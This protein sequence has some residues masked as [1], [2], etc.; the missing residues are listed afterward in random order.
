MKIIVKAIMLCLLGLIL[1][2]CGTKSTSAE[3]E[4]VAT[5]AFSTGGGTFD[6]AV[7]VLISCTTAYAT[8]R[9]TLDNTEP[10]ASSTEY[11]EVLHIAT[12]TTL[13]AKAF[14]SGWVSSSTRSATYAFTAVAAPLILPPGGTYNAAQL[15]SI[16]CA[17]PEA[18]IYYTTDGTVPTEAS[19][20][21]TSPINISSAIILKA[22]AFVEGKTPSPVITQVYN[23]QI[24]ALDFNPVGGV[25]SV[26]QI[27]N[28]T[29][30]IA[31]VQIR[32]TLDGTD[33]SE[34]ST[35]YTH[36]LSIA[37]NTIVK[38]RAYKSGW[39]SSDVTAAAYQINVPDQMVYVPGATF[40]NG[41][42]NVS[43][44]PFYMSKYEVNQFDW[45]MI[46][47]TD[48]S[49]Y[50]LTPPGIYADLPVESITWYDAIEYCN[51][52]SISEGYAACYSYTGF[53]TDPSYWPAGW[54]TDNNNHANIVCDWAANGYR[55]PT[56]MEWMFA[57]KGGNYS[58]GYLYSGSDDL[59]AVAWYSGNSE[60][61]TSLV[62]TKAA[63]EL[64][65]YDMSGNVWEYCWDIFGNLPVTDVANPHG[66]ASGIARAIRGGSCLQD[67]SNCTVA[68]RFNILPLISTNVVGL[69][70]VRKAQ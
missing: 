34:S 8:I 10:N 44:S 47:L 25:Y 30:N 5:P 68:R 46:M 4:Q 45:F 56:E 33:P 28:I 39:N 7:D 26:A 15:V 9:Y 18:V 21:Y 29:C 32:Y 48:P 2:S 36:P 58:Q 49:L 20:L 62:G 59:D 38:A 12:N 64:G 66:A 42:S 37:F 22:R 27:V 54:N 11:T 60:E 14:K 70:V 43:L 35:L 55:L 24:T 23:L 13:K 16:S 63:N 50:P 41:F 17:T 40:N 51:K 19:S 3:D 53:G 6:N 31:N 57:A 67:A 61:M 69:R 65:L 52:R 1:M